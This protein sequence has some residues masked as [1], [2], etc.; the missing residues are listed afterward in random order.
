MTK[1]AILHAVRKF[2]A[3]LAFAVTHAHIIMEP[4]RK[5]ITPLD[6]APEQMRKR[7]LGAI[8]AALAREERFL[9][10]EEG[11]CKDM[12]VHPDATHA[13]MAG[14][15]PVYDK[16]L[17]TLLRDLE[18]LER[19]AEQAREQ[20]EHLE[21]ELLLACDARFDA[22]VAYEMRGVDPAAVDKNSLEWWIYGEADFRGLGIEG[23]D[24]IVHDSVCCCD[25]CGYDVLQT[26]TDE[27]VACRNAYDGWETPYW[28]LRGTRTT[29][30]CHAC[31][32][33]LLQGEAIYQAA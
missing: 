2:I 12:S 17:D 24:V 21:S 4:W 26:S 32:E 15:E 1:N 20:F 9:A 19:R 8:E 29:I 6:T 30:L 22:F 13:E 33:R 27:C 7:A 11:R 23:D 16:Y 25:C 5:R 28:R 31:Y 14:R 18:D 3:S 10:E